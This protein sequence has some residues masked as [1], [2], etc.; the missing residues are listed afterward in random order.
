[1]NKQFIYLTGILVLAMAASFAVTAQETNATANN[2]TLNNTIL[3]CGHS[4][5]PNS[6][7]QMILQMQH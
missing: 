6:T 1:M 4:N 5:P 3:K 2:A 7:Q